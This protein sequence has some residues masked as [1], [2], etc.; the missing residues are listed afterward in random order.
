MPSVVGVV[1]AIAAE[2]EVLEVQVLQSCTGVGSH[3]IDRCC[4]AWVMHSRKAQAP[5]CCRAVAPC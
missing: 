3:L 1:Y 4:W 2:Y 5:A